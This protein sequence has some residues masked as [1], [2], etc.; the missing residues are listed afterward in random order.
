MTQFQSTLTVNVVFRELAV[1]VTN[2]LDTIT[3]A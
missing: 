1:N 2:L 3:V